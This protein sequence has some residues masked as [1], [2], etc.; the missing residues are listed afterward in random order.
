MTTTWFSNPWALYPAAI[1]PL[2]TMLSLRAWRKR[3]AALAQL[4]SLHGLLLVRRGPRL[5]RGLCLFL[6]MT[7][8]IAGAAGPQWGIDTNPEALAGPTRDVV[9]VLDLSRSM[10]AEQPSRQDLALR[11][12][13][14]LCET[15]KK[16]GGYRVAL[17]VFAGRP[18]LVFPLTND[19]D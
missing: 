4:G 1:L 7:L 10:L 16:R 15:F 13:N 5:V 19:Y 11:G 6:G 3:R 18:K 2:L 9:I 17:V 12:L 14:H 8:L